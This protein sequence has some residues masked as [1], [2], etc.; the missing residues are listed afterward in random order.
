[1]TKPGRNDP[2]PC[3][4]GK[5]YKNCCLEKD[6]TSRL[7]DHQ[8]RNSEQKALE[9]LSA[10]AQQ[11][12]SQAQ[13][14]VASNLF[15][16]GNYGIEAWNSLARD[17]LGRFLDWFAFD[18]RLEGSR[19]RT[20]DV[21][22]EE[23]PGLL[24]DELQ[25]LRAWSKSFLSLYR[26]ELVRPEGRLRL[27]DVL[28][29]VEVEATD[30]RLSRM[31]QAGD[32]ILGRLLQS[33]VSHLSWGAIL[34]P[35]DCEA[36]FADFVRGAFRRYQDRTPEASWPDFLSLHGYVLNHHLLRMSA[37]AGA[38]EHSGRHYDAWDT[39]TKLRQ[40]EKRLA[41]RVAVEAEKQRKKVVPEMKNSGELLR[42]TSGGIVLPRHVQ[43]E[44]D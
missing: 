33:D 4:S 37:E 19:K 43:Y 18:Y 7:R 41:E 31:G 5:K 36:G 1:M 24:P 6:R 30:H 3:G 15:W 39:V 28:Q 38:S 20:I 29:V 11:S 14:A 32:L 8:W 23:R 2:C 21:F 22:L 26:I 13:Y 40:A 12:Q 27:R 35:G 10:F 44:D 16:N 42:Q 34:L 17:E 25:M 9:Q